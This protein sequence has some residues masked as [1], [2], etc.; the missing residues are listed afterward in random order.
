MSESTPSPSRQQL[1]AFA[2]QSAKEFVKARF[3]GNRDDRKNIAKQMT[4][5]NWKSLRSA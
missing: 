4:K 2:R 1:R 3:K 5:R